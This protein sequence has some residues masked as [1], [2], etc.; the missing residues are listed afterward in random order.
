MATGD[1]IDI[2]YASFRALSIYIGFVIREVRRRAWSRQIESFIYVV[3]L[4]D[5]NSPEILPQ[6]GLFIC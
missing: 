2:A 1:I 4:S 3:C 6:Q 5:L